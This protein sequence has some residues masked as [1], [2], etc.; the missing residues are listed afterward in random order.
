MTKAPDRDLRKP[1]K[2]ATIVPLDERLGIQSVEVGMALLAA[3]SRAPGPLALKALAEAAGMS[4]SKAHRYLV[5]YGRAGLVVQDPR[6]SKYDLGPLALSIGMA[7]LSRF[8]V[9]RA[10][11]GVLEEIRDRI[12]ETVAIFVWTNRGPAVARILQ[13]GHPVIITM[14]VGTV[15]PILPTAA[16]RVFAAFLPAIQTQPYIDSELSAQQRPRAL[17]DKQVEAIVA[18]V[19]AR[20]LARIEGDYVPGVSVLAVPIFDPDGHIA[21]VLGVLG[22]TEA[23]E[24]SYD[25]P[26]ARALHEYAERLSNLAKPR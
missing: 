5:S 4:S 20:R 1:P 18:D 7:A 10:A 16:G 9:L 12:N 21:A 24:A 23:L 3:L 6:S 14:Q 19:R 11:E 22:R 17:D 2:S 15:L 25:G 8:D 13:S 26:V